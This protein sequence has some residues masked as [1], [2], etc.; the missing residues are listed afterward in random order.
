VKR[1]EGVWF[2]TT[3]K[4]AKRVLECAGIT[5]SVTATYGSASLA[6]K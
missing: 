2:A 5:P 6:M 1:R 3:E 4:I